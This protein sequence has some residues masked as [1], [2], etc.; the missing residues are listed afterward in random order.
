MQS[1]AVLPSFPIDLPEVRGTSAAG[2][3]REAVST[4]WGCKKTVSAEVSEPDVVR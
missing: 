1:K 2:E 3:T 4:H